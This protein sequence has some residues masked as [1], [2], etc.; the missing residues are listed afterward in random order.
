MASF[1]LVS[2]VRHLLVTR[3]ITSSASARDPS[4]QSHQ[5]LH[6]DA[7]QG[8]DRRLDVL[9]Q[10]LI[11]QVAHELFELRSNFLPGE[12][13]G[14]EPRVILHL[15]AVQLAALKP[16]GHSARNLAGIAGGEAVVRPRLDLS[17]QGLDVRSVNWPGV[18]L[19]RLNVGV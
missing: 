3:H 15:V 1:S 13:P 16:H 11:G 10:A 12:W 7:F 6:L 19:R 14:W 9:A 2:P 5:F 18:E 8:G 4:K 17:K